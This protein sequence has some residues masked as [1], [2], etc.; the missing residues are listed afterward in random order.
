MKSFSKFFI[1]SLVTFYFW[2]TFSD[3]GIIMMIRP[4]PFCAHGHRPT[5]GCRIAILM[6]IAEG[7]LASRAERI[8]EKCHTHKST[9]PVRP[10][11]TWGPHS[12]AVSCAP[13]RTPLVASC[14]SGFRRLALNPTC[15]IHVPYTHRA[16]SGQHTP[17]HAQTR[18]P[19]TILKFFVPDTLFL[20]LPND[21][22]VWLII[23][24][25]WRK[26]KP[27]IFPIVFCNIL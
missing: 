24:T 25:S 14:A 10:W 22:L 20:Q 8:A 11:R 19:K 4:Y 23:Y 7:D 13:S 2:F 9:C 15:F 1:F 6:E 27:H 12:S 17:Q 3:I 18:I 5:D 16:H 21:A 26:Y